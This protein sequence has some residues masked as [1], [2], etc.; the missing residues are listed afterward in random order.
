MDEAILNK[1]SQILEHDTE[2]IT[3]KD[4]VWD[5]SFFQKFYVIKKILCN[6]KKIS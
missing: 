4:H 6:K 1:I 5:I 3:P 2:N